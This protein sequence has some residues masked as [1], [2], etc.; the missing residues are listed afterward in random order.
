MQ[1]RYTGDIG[2]FGKFGLLRTRQQSLSLQ[3]GVVW[4]LYP[5]ETHNEDG[6]FTQYLGSG[7]SPYRKCD[8][9]LWLSLKTMVKAGTR[10]V[11]AIQSS[12]ILGKSTRFFDRFTDNYSEHPGNSASAKTARSEYREQ[13]LSDALR[14]MKAASLI[15][16]D[17]DNGLEVNSCAKTHQRKAG[18]FAFYSEA[19]QFFD[20]ADVMVVYHHLNR[21]KNHGTHMNQL[22]TRAADLKSRIGCD[23]AVFGLRYP[24][25]SARAFFVACRSSIVDRVESAFTDFLKSEW[26]KYW[27]TEFV[28]K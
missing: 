15:F 7:T 3:L 23:G 13:W 1:D 6:K 19:Q 12:G 11:A 5:N 26:G 22:E 25:F 21:H 8:P 2:D 20:D 24:P 28:R 18:K 4:Y 17:P 9:V 27:D 14:E 16:L 10:S